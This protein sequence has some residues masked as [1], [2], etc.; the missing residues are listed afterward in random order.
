MDENREKRADNRINQTRKQLINDID[1]M[2][3]SEKRKARKLENLQNSFQNLNKNMD[4]CLDLIS[5]SIRGNNVDSMIDEMRYTNK[6]L[7]SKNN[8][9]INDEIK[10]IKKRVN[11]LY[12]E[13]EQLIN[14]KE[15][16]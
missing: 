9:K 8:Q 6:K 1:E 5:K 13:K 15:Q 16:K 2:L 3:S 7:L 14:K 10:E 12:L 4:K 11:K